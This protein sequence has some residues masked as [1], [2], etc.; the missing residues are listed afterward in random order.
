MTISHSN[1]LSLLSVPIVSA[2]IGYVTNYIA[3]RML[4]RPHSPRR[5]L[6]VTLHGLVPRRQK[7]IAHSIGTMIERDLFS[8]EDIQAALQNADTAEAAAD[9]LNEQVDLFAERLTGQN[10]M[11]GAF[12][13]GGLLQQ[14]KGILVGQ[15]NEKFPE[16]IERVVEKAEHNLDVSA[17]VEKKIQE[18]DL[19]KLESLIYEVS[20]RELKTIEV[21][22][23]VLGFLVGLGQVGIMVVLGS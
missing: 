1:L 10:P 16:F 2:L 7:E 20:A 5:F 12:L 18:F 3:V 14:V 8:H 21:L 19:T 6:G 4:F 15:M 17:I 9:F 13:Q 22:G 11:L 23:G